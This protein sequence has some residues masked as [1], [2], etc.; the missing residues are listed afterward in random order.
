MPTILVWLLL[1]SCT[2]G[3]SVERQIDQ[4]VKMYL[5]FAVN[6]YREA[7]WKGGS[8]EELFHPH[9]NG[10]GLGTGYDGLDR[11]DRSFFGMNLFT[12]VI[13][14]GTRKGRARADREK[15]AEEV[16]DVFYVKVEY[17]IIAK[18]QDGKIVVLDEPAQTFQYL[19]FAA[20]ETDGKFK[21]IDFFPTFGTDF[22]GA[23]YF[24]DHFDEFSVDSD[25]KIRLAE[26]LGR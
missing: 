23:R 15:P 12:H 20:D 22:V 14:A 18:T 2:S 17:T 8:G 25:L 6:H 11:P 10:L 7:K 16:E 5:D 9:F 13:V 3:G 26:R 24:L 1:I 21:I 19:V 4:S